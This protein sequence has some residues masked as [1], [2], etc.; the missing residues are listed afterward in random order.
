[1][2]GSSSPAP[3]PAADA[4]AP[5][6]ANVLGATKDPTGEVESPNE[7]P[8]T[9]SSATAPVPNQ[10]L[11]SSLS[12]SPP[13]VVEA[14]LGISDYLSVSSSSSSSSSSIDDVVAASGFLGVVKARYSDFVVH[15]VN[16][17][18]QMARLTETDLPKDSEAAAAA[19]AKEDS[20]EEALPTKNEKVENTMEVKV[21]GEEAKPE[22]SPHGQLAKMINDDAVAA[23]VFSMLQSHEEDSESSNGDKSK[24]VTLPALEKAQ[25]K[26]VHEWVRA[27][28]LQQARAD[29]LDGKIRIWHIKFE[30]EMP[31]YQKFG[32][33]DDNNN[34]RS[35]NNPNN[36]GRKRVK[37]NWPADRPDFLQFVMYKENIDTNVAAKELNRRGNSGRIGYAGMKD[38]RGITSQF[39]T[40]YRTTPDQIVNATHGSRRRQD[41]RPSG[42]GGNTKEKG[43]SVV[44]VGNFQYVDKELRLGMLKGNRFDIVIRN[45]KALEEQDGEEES[46]DDGQRERRRTVLEAAAQGVKAKGFINYFGTQRFG[47]FHDTHLVGLAVLKGDYRAAVDILMAPKPEDR[48]D[49]AKARKDWQ[50]RFQYG[51]KEENERDT[52]KRVLKGMNR[53][54][55]AEIAIV[56]SLAKRPMDYKRAFSCIPRNLKAMF[57]HAVQSLIWNRAAS[58]RIGK[59]DREN[60]LVGDLVPGSE[61]KF[62]VHSVTEEDVVANKYSL[63]D[64]LIPLVG[65]KT[66]LPSNELSEVIRS[67]LKDN[68]ITVDMFKKI[69]D[70]DLILNGDYRNVICH[71]TDFDYEIKEYF[72]PLQPLL[73]TDLMKLHDEDIKIE[74]PT[75]TVATMKTAMVVGFTLPSSSYATIALRELMKRPTSIE[76]QREQKLE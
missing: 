56:Q 30:K 43:V 49:A 66:T 4:S 64:I 70:R 13:D 74:P 36:S 35:N 68:G 51:E 60:V 61:G 27:A 28:L 16:V 76:F 7:P 71:P 23:N 22:V 2:S 24:F 52:A 67:I 8:A 1:M 15:E 34:G 58:H 10:D 65:V 46:N 47:K 69:Q 19:A 39:C 38:K 3:S 17:Q 41:N 62:N 59:M 54:M 21:G 37:R 53:F 63:E 40:L 5:A 20:M 25:R 45:V 26:A 55:T 11:S 48:P 33:N 18:G 44:Q 14:S 12:Q 75:D 50:N 57:I 31:N 29:T 73:Q 42:G 6:E 72:D 32:N 9:S